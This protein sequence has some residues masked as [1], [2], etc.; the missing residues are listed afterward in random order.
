[1][2][3]AT[4]R[5]IC[6]YRFDNFM[7]RGG[8]SIFIS[9][10][11][12]FVGILVS[13]SL[14]RGVVMLIDPSGANPENTEGFFSHVYVVFLEL[15]DPGNMNQDIHSSPTF[16][17][18]GV[19]AGLAGV[20]ILS[21]LIA[22]ITTALDQKLHQLKKGHSKVVEDDHTLILGWNDR[23]VEIIRELVIANESED[24]GCV[25][26]LSE[27]D[28]EEMDDYLALNMHDT[29]GTRVVTRSGSMS[30]LVNLDI[31][32]ITTCKSVIV[33]ATCNESDSPEAKAASDTRVIKTILGLMV[34]KGDHQT[35]NIVAELFSERNR[36][37]ANQI[38]PDEVSTIDGVDILA[39]VIVQTSRSIGLSVVYAEIMSFDG[40]EMY[41]HAADWPDTPFGRLQF[42]FPDG[43]LMGIRRASGELLVNPS[44]D[45]IVKAGDEVLILADDDSTIEYRTEPV[46]TARDLPLADHRVRHAVEHE[47]IVG[48]NPKAPILIEQYA[49]YVLEG[50]R[51]DVLIEHPTE[52]QRAAI[53]DLQG[54]IDKL[55]ITL[56]ESSPL[57]IETF[58]ELDPFKYDNIV[59]LSQGGIDVEPETTDSETIIILLLLRRIFEASPERASR[60]TLI[61][62]VMDSRNQE[63]VAR[64]GVHDFIISNRLVS[65]LLAQISE[66]RDIKAVYDDLF[67]EAGS[68]IYLKPVSLYFDEFPVEASFADLMRIAQ[69]RQ[70]ACLGIK[71]KIHERELSNNFGVKL[72][73]EK[74]TS[75][76]LNRDDCL[77]VLAEDDT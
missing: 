11:I 59:I 60:T 28:K 74:N 2:P 20:V 17:I 38:S 15:T 36:R 56:I 19:I 68:E 26:I 37:I 69:K 31:V 23:V 71:L 73:P 42:H 52:Q 53:T 70:E 33:L 48:W 30:A 61:S 63:L 45:T 16:K 62:E 32:S 65:M 29:K 1:M 67:E 57:H 8:S 76:T 9:L 4:F 13:I 77:V 51:I 21:M 64:A 75:Y 18:P 47:L 46:A 5:Q 66:Q 50:S 54:S 24:D 6:R 10:V 25:V 3:D 49:D 34:A 35:L 27:T 7:A 14:I 58:E 39:K 72:I 40:C 41:F 43:A 44:A 55:H 12:V 22:F